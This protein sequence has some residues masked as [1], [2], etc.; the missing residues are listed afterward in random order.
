MELEQEPPSFWRAKKENLKPLEEYSPN[1]TSVQAEKK[2]D[3]PEIAKK[4]E[5][6]PMGRISSLKIDD[7]Q[8]QIQTEVHTG[9]NP[10]ITT[11]IICE[12]QIL[13]KIERKWTPLFDQD[14]K[15]SKEQDKI[16]EHHDTIVSSLNKLWP[17][18]SKA[19]NLT[20]DLL[21]KTVKLVANF[22]RRA[23]GRNICLHYL[24]DS[25]AS[26]NKK[27]PELAAFSIDE[28]GKISLAPFDASKDQNIKSGVYQWLSLFTEKC[29]SL[30]PLFNTKEI[31]ELTRPLELQLE[32]IDFYPSEK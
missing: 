12:G 29:N 32:W 15:V 22:A 23:V 11:L 13:K 28:E 17:L 20:V 6:L 18:T 31:R 30:S 19:H 16:N 7:K 26:L 25:K 10:S 14:D 27:F 8:F 21:L 4:T 24:I 1:K 2:S 3:F 5:R 9:E